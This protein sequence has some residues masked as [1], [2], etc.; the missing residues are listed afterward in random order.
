MDNSSMSS[1]SKIT[2]S[3]IGYWLLWGLL[4][5]LLY[6]FVY[7]ILIS[8]I[9]SVVSQAILVII[10]QGIMVLFIWKMSTKSALQKYT[11]SYS[12]VPIVMRNLVIFTVV[13][14]VFNGM[15][16]L[17]QVNS[18][19]DKI[20]D[21]DYKLKYNEKRLSYI[22]D[23]DEMEEYNNQKEKAIKKA[24]SQATTYLLIVEIGL[25]AVYLGVLRFEKQELLKY[26][27]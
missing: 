10:M 20:V 12:D 7:I 4:F 3:L 2:Q 24:K 18:S 15:Y 6:S 22:Y 26:L 5:G 27:R 14:C 25:T 8:P 17:S 23:D 16:N 21:S 9:E 19:I 11:I 1:S 13:I